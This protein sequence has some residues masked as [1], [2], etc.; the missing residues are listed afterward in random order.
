MTTT[1]VT[2][3]NSS[4]DLAAAPKNQL[5]SKEAF[6]QL[7]VSQIKNQNPLEPTNGVEFLTQLAQFTQLEQTMGMRSDLGQIRDAITA[8]PAETEL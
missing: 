6:L 7:L 8:V 3:T 5:A 1:T 4:T 2:G